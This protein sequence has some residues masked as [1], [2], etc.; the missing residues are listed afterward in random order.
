MPFYSFIHLLSIVLIRLLGEDDLALVDLNKTIEVSGGVGRSACQAF[1][2][3]G[4]ITFY[5]YFAKEE[6]VKSFIHD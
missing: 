4:Q 6:G 1:C 2:Q 3:R 5:D